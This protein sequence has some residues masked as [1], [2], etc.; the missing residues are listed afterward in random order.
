M[1]TTTNPLA[2]IPT[3]AGAVRLEDW[4]LGRTSADGMPNV[5]RGFT[6]GRRGLSSCVTNV[7]RSR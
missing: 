7:S 4:E 3:P 6:P 2:N 1:E 5:D